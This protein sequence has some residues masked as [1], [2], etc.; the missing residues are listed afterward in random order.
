MVWDACFFFRV[1]ND[2]ELLN[3]IEHYTLIYYILQS[4]LVQ[5]CGPYMPTKNQKKLKLD[6]SLE[7]LKCLHTNKFLN[8]QQ[9]DEHTNRT[10]KKR[11]IPVL[12]LESIEEMR[13]HIVEVHSEAISK[14]SNAE[15]KILQPY[16]GAS[17]N[18]TPFQNVN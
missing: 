2:R 13:A 3:Y 10:P 4:S 1:Q 9:V 14:C 12:S 15:S 11:A 8:F 18:R 6:W 7:Q 5:Y 16:L 17:M